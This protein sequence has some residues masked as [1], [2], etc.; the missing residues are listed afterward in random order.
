MNEH[1]NTQYYDWQEKLALPV[2]GSAN[3]QDDAICVDETL[4]CWENTLRIRI[5]TN[6]TFRQT[7]VQGTAARLAADLSSPP[8]EKA[9][10]VWDNTDLNAN[11]P[12][13]IKFAD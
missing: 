7:R 3:M 4:W 13:T 6:Y 8:A 12:F 1:A 9:L 5:T 11:S 2:S 10:N